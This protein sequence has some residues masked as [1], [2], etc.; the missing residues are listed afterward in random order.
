MLWERARINKK[1][2]NGV[3]RAGRFFTAR[4]GFSFCDAKQKGDRSRYFC[5]NWNRM[6]KIVPLIC[7]WAV[8]EKQARV[9]VEDRY[10]SDIRTQ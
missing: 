2:E 10:E 6:G 4:P 1:T 3:G 7:A 9:R 5:M 8:A